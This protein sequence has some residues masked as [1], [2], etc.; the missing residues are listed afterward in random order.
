[1][2]E[3]AEASASVNGIG[4]ASEAVDGIGAASDLNPTNWD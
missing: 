3:E 1:M 4:Y 2:A